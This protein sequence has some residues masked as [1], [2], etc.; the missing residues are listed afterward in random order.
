MFNQDE[1]SFI[2]AKK[3]LNRQATKVLHDIT[4]AY[5]RGILDDPNSAAMF[6]Q[7]LALVC[8]GKLQGHMNDELCRVEWSLTPSYEKELEALKKMYIDTQ[9]DA[10]KVVRGPWA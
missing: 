9:I 1:I 7:L 5:Q 10:G 4:D 6:A 2:D 3:N 8:E